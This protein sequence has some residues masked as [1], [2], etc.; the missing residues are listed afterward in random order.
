MAK[1]VDYCNELTLRCF[2]QAVEL[3]TLR[4]RVRDLEA[5]LAQFTD[6]FGDI[7]VVTPKQHWGL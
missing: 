3:V 2:A 7:K 4:H 5:Q 6:A 1:I